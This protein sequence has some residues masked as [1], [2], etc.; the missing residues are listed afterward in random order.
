MNDAKCPVCYPARW[1]EPP[2]EV[3]LR[4]DACPVRDR[5]NKITLALE[6]L[7]QLENSLERGLN[8]TAEQLRA[9]IDRLRTP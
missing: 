3:L 7:A 5:H 1:D 6:Y 4:P 8:A 9:D 2:P